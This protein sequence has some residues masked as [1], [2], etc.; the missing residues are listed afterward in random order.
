MKTFDVLYILFSIAAVISCFLN[1]NMIADIL[2]KI[3]AIILIIV[4]CLLKKGKKI[5]ILYI[6]L[7]LLLAYSNTLIHF[8][9]RYLKQIVFISMLEKTLFFVV[10]LS[11]QKKKYLKH[12]LKFNL[13]V[14]ISTGPLYYF[15]NKSIPEDNGIIFICYLLTCVSIALSYVNFINI[16]NRKMVYYFLSILLFCFAEL[17]FGIYFYFD[18]ISLYLAAGFFILGFARHTL[19]SF[20]LEN[21]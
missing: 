12:T 5:E 11:F 16:N 21:T 18:Q 2:F 7:F 19:Y 6:F 15:F 17:F 20:M 3:S 8:G 10:A 1:I 13:L 9:E 14:F 4:S